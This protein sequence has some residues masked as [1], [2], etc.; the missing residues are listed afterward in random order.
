[1][2]SYEPL[3]RTMKK[4]GYTQKKL[5]EAGLSPFITISRGG[6]ID[7]PT[8]NRLCKF[9]NCGIEDIVCWVPGEHKDTEMRKVNWSAMA[10]IASKNNHSLTSLSLAIGKSKGALN[11]GRQR[12]TALSIFDLEM[13]ADILKCD[14]QELIND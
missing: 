8:V 14:V 12:N 6:D 2:I 3:R 10:D 1:M 4:N 7:V 5:T 11:L 13:I 9:F